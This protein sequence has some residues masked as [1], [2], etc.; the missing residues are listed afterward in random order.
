MTFF[1]LTQSANVSPLVMV[2]GRIVG[3]SVVFQTIQHVESAMVT[4]SE[5]DHSEWLFNQFTKRK[6]QVIKDSKQQNQEGAHGS[7]SSFFFIISSE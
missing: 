4:S 5:R 6:K 2:L 3:P 1:R 7:V